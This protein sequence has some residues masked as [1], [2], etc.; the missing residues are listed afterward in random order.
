MKLL[1]V[2]RRGNLLFLESN[3]RGLESSSS[4]FLLADADPPPTDTPTNFLKELNT[5]APFPP[6]NSRRVEDDEAR[7]ATG[8]LTR[9]LTDL[10]VII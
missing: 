2:H 10:S 1:K 4:A 3:N 8:V 6:S 7:A 9:D 5:A